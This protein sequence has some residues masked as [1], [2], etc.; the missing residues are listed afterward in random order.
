MDKILKFRKLAITGT[1]SGLLLFFMFMTFETPIL[2]AV[3]ICAAIITLIINVLLV[4]EILQNERKSI[5]SNLIIIII[6][7]L[8]SIFLIFIGRHFAQS[9]R[10]DVINNTDQTINHWSISGCTSLWR[11][12][13]YPKQTETIWVHLSGECS[14]EIEYSQN[15]INK[16]E[17]IVGKLKPGLFSKIEFYIQPENSNY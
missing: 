2:S 11:N 5:V 13:Q 9:T 3:I 14:V 6:S 1:I 17:I 15:G 8:I 4:L 16:K 12:N 10:I 7:S